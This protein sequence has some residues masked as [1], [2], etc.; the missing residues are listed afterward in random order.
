M[1]YTFKPWAPNEAKNGGEIQ[2]A[3]NQIRIHVKQYTGNLHC[4]K[5]DSTSYS[6]Y[7]TNI[8]IAN[9]KKAWLEARGL[10]TM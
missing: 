10:N 5:D 7:F 2:F 1:M 9:D 6:K 8:K 3:I 4:I